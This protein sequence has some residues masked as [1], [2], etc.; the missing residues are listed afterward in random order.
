V[1]ACGLPVTRILHDGGRAT[2]VELAGRAPVMAGKAVIAGVAPRACPRLPGRLATRLRRAM[3]V[4]HAPGTMMIHLALDGLPTGGGRGAAGA[5]PMSISRR[6]STRWRAPISRRRRGF[7]PTSRSS[8]SA[9]RRPSTR[10]RAPD[11]KHI[12]WV[13]VRMVPGEIRGDAAGRSPQPTG[14]GAAKEPS[15]NARSTFSSAMRRNL[16][17]KDPRPRV[18]SP[19]DLEA[20]NPNLV[21]GDQICG[22]HHLAQNF[23][24]RPARGTCRRGDAAEGA[25]HLTGAAV[26]PG[27]GHRRGAG[28]SARP[29]AG[30][31][32]TMQKKPEQQGD[33]TT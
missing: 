6:R 28:I 18:V 4:R 30:R 27:A 25:L 24:F 14:H 23:L 3:R 19:E 1:V 20:D 32:T 12:L 9:S 11:G 5:S 13:Q 7:C 22:S 33:D 2:G 10:R 29:A 31:I 26:W 21:G 16:R 8:S 17:S 15:P